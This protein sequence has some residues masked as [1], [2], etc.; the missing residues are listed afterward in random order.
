VTGDSEL[1]DLRLESLGAGW[2][3]ASGGGALRP[4]THEICSA[5]NSLAPTLDLKVRVFFIK[6]ILGYS[7]TA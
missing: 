7:E 5:I 1:P 2:D 6:M 4:F 3:A